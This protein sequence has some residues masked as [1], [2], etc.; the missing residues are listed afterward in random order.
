MLNVNYIQYGTWKSTYKIQLSPFSYFDYFLVGINM[1]NKKYYY[2][3]NFKLYGS[4][5]I[6][7]N[8]Y[9]CFYMGH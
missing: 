4:D 1:L 5:D 9:N 8:N 3:A 2:S 7:H 6:F